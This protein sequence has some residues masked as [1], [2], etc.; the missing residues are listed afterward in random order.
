MQHYC[1]ER[2]LPKLLYIASLETDSPLVLQDTPGQVYG[3]T[4]VRI[5][6]Y[7]TAQHERYLAWEQSPLRS[8]PMTAGDDHRV[9][10]CLF[11]LNPNHLKDA[12]VADMVQL[13]E[14]VPVVPMIAKVRADSL[15]VIFASHVLVRCVHHAYHCK[16]ASKCNLCVCLS[17]LSGVAIYVPF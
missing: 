4:N 6:D 10:A 8:V 12:E 9:D 7:I 11:F 15:V 17:G 2:L 3:Q 5:P 14:L 1:P 16:T 13:S